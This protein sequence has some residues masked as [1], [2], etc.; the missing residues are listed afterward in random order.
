MVLV[1]LSKSLCGCHGIYVTLMVFV[2]LSQSLC[3]CHGIYVTLMVFVCL[4]WPVCVCHGLRVSVTVCVW[5][6]R[7]VCGCHDLC[8]SLT[9]LGGCFCSVFNRL[10][11]IVTLW[12]LIVYSSPSCASQPIDF[13]QLNHIF[14]QYV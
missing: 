6:S 8:A 13:H 7:P 9:I 10:T 1:C 3:G 5:L 2:C 12:F 11:V 14:C 4:S